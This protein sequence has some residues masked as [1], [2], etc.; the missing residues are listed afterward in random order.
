MAALMSRGEDLNQRRI[1]PTPFSTILFTVA[2]HP[3]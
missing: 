3:A 1:S 2:R